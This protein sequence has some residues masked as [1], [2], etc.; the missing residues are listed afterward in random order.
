MKPDCHV[1]RKGDYNFGVIEHSVG[2]ALI[3]QHHYAKGCS[4]TGNM[5]AAKRQIDGEVAGVAQWLPPTKVCAQSVFK[6]YWWKVISLTRLVVLPSEPQNTASMLIGASIRWLRTLKNESG[7]RKWHALV[8]FADDSEGH[9]G[10]IYR[11]TNWLYMGKTKPYARWVTSDGAQVS[12][13]CG[14]RTRT[15]Q[16]MRAL[17]YEIKGFYWKHKFVKFI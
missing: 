6:D 7:A 2:A 9:T 3:R 14:P 15:A 8:T 4:K 17:G 1:A 5:F 13:K 10:N 12:T 11:A 16:E